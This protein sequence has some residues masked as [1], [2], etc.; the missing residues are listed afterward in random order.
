M[1]SILRLDGISKSFDSPS[2]GGSLEIL[3]DINLEIR[4]GE[5][6]SITGRSG[7]GKSTLLYIASLIE[8][9][10]QG[11]VFYDGQDATAW[12]DR[13]LA[14]LR[15][16]RMGFVFQNS[17][18]LEDFSALENVML[19]LLNRG[20]AKDDARRKAVDMLTAMGLGNRLDHRPMMLSGG[21]RQRV[22]IARAVCPGPAILFAD[23]PTGSLDEESQSMV[24]D[25]LFSLVRE[26]GIALMLVTHDSAFAGRCS[27]VLT[28]SHKELRC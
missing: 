19:V 16:E 14:T 12:D 28:L 5:S 4:E 18:L 24:E 21:E 20:F 11:R 3:R 23:E 7:S 15:R 6:L 9:P 2:G 26:R 27:R 17:L 10:T 8:K 1:N 25:L 13:R 22:A